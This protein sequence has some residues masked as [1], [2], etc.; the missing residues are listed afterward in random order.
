[1]MYLVLALPAL[2]A[3][4]PVRDHSVLKWSVIG[5]LL[6][7]FIGFRHEVGGDWGGYLR[8]FSFIDFFSFK[9]VILE[10]DPGY[11]LLNWWVEKQ[12]F[13]IYTVN[14]VC[15]AIFTTGLVAFA[16]RQPYPWLALAV[17]FPYL[18]LVLGMGYTRQGVALGFIFLSLNALEFHQFK[19]YLLYIAL[20]TLFHKTALIMIPLGFFIFGKGWFFR[21]V[22]LVV[23]AYVL[24]DAL[25][26]D[27]TEDLWRNY[28]EAQMISQ[29]AQI[30][31][32]MNLVPS[33][34]LLAYWKTWRTAFPNYWFWFW[35]AAGSVVAVALVGFASTAVDRIALYFIPIQVVVFARLPFLLRQRIS[36]GTVTAG[37]VLGYTLVL[38]VWLN[39]ASHAHYWLPYQNMLFL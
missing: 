22:A 17:A 7:I 4:R 25:V 21:A 14:L 15:G 27:S 30:R 35:I 19:R 16:R 9:E 29:G 10:S 18:V 24:F 34:I 20:A 8:L 39:Y 36:P 26:A 28:V 11:K 1:M 31:V 2:Q 5:L 13:E 37:I 32:L 33:L 6:A 38:Y 12:G 3:Q 23:A